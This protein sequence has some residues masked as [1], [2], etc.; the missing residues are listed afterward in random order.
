MIALSVSQETWPMR[1]AFTISRGSR[2][3]AH[4]LVAELND[5]TH[6]GCGECMPYD[7]SI[8]YEGLFKLNKSIPKKDAAILEEVN[9]PAIL[10][11]FLRETIADITRRSGFQPFLIPSVNF[12]KVRKERLKKK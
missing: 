8:E 6:V 7:L 10:F 5:G 4:V 12:V 2:T 1:G 9:C 11:P 3:E